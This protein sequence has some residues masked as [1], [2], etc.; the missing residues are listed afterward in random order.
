MDY[1]FLFI[2]GNIGFNQK[3]QSDEKQIGKKFH[4]HKIIILYFLKAIG[5]YILSKKI[6]NFIP[7][8][9]V[10]YMK[11]LPN[12]IKMICKALI[13]E[14]KVYCPCIWRVTQGPCLITALI[15]VHV[16]LT[17]IYCCACT[18]KIPSAQ[19]CLGYNTIDL[20]RTLFLS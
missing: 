11:V 3:Q 9:Y 7:T 6:F 18:A 20:N 8:Y 13:K 12:A 4:L 10:N 1:L 5:T 16:R 19:L 17:M 15:R 14:L 2:I